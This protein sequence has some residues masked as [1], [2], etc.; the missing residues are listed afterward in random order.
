M[1]GL[2]ILFSSSSSL[3]N[4]VGTIMVSIWAVRL[5]GYLF[6]RILKIGEDKRFDD[7]RGNFFAFLA[8]WII[9]IV[10]VWCVGMPINVVNAATETLSV[11]ISFSSF[12]SFF[13]SIGDFVPFF[14][15]SPTSPSPFFFF[16]SC[17][18]LT[19]TTAIAGIAMWALGLTIE[20][21]A[22]AQKFTF[23]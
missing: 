4:T 9:Q 13:F 16:F 15:Y 18:D 21:L 2:R 17:K 3:L 22:D 7:K 5:A 23:K 6:Y 14:L 1:G 12:F 11:S 19:E 20:T 8:F 10:W